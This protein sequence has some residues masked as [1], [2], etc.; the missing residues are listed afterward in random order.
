[1]APNLRSF[2]D[3]RLISLGDFETYGRTVTLYVRP[4][5]A[6]RGTSGPWITDSGID[7][8]LPPIM[9]DG[10]ACVTLRGTSN[11]SWLPAVPDVTS[12]L[13]NA[14][15][16]FDIRSVWR[17]NGNDYRIDVDLPSVK[18]DSYGSAWYLHLSFSTYFIPSDLNINGDTRHLV[19]LSPVSRRINPGVCDSLPG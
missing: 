11:L 7:M 18:L 4:A 12:T 17:E 8:V 19:V 3:A 16:Q 9:W 13:R 2:A 15:S 10:P 5:V 6:I 14:D 1:M